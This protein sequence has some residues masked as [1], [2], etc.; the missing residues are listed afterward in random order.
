MRGLSQFCD[1]NGGRQST[2]S[3]RTIC[4]GGSP[5]ITLLLLAGA[6]AS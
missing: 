1:R 4:R 5:V 2:H 3:S 6:S